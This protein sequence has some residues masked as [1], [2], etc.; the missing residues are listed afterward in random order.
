MIP[1]KRQ[2][3]K[4]ETLREIFG[5]ESVKIHIPSQRLWVQNTYP[6]RDFGVEFGTRA[7]QTTAV[8]L[9]DEI[10]DDREAG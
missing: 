7:H 4:I 9:A 8:Q 1:S 3:T 10:L 2:K 5:E 6:L